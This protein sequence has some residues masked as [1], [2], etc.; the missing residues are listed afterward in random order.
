MASYQSDQDGLVS[1]PDPFA[2]N[3]K[4]K[5]HVRSWPDPEV[6]VDGKGVRLLG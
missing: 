4:P 5:G 6:P 1:R 3:V 2:R